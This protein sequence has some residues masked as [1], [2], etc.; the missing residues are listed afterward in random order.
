M[1]MM[2]MTTT[3]MSRIMGMVLVLPG[4]KELSTETRSRTLLSANIPPT[5]T[6]TVAAV[7]AA[8]LRTMIWVTMKTRFSDLIH[9][10]N[11]VMPGKQAFKH[12]NLL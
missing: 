3:T 11:R 6:T 9:N 5:R 2:T 4:K 7:M 12:L 8:R 1:M 10:H